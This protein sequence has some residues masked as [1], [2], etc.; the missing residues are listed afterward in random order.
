MNTETEYD[1]ERPMTMKPN[2][3]RR[4]RNRL[5]LALTVGIL[6]A[7][8]VWAVNQSLDTASS[9]L[10]PVQLTVDDRPLPREN[11]DNSYAQVIQRVG[12]SVVQVDITAKAKPAAAMPGVPG[13]NH[14]FFRRF[15]DENT[16][17]RPLPEM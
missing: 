9:R 3:H 8:A 5:T 17:P 13:L 12:P 15:F 11:K 1:N 7:G 14:P 2:T 6:S 10:T 4:I 16:L